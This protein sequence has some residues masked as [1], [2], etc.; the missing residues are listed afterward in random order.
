MLISICPYNLEADEGETYVETRM[1]EI[2]IMV[3]VIT[4]DFIQHIDEDDTEPSH[5]T[6]RVIVANIPTLE[7]FFEA[8]ATFERDG[9]VDI[10]S[11]DTDYEKWEYQGIELLD[12]SHKKYYRLPC[13]NV[14]VRGGVY[15]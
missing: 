7:K 12:K 9:Y 11:Y 1:R 8:V 5:F 6:H 15:Y 13:L 14:E 4:S 3:S 2:G 10:E